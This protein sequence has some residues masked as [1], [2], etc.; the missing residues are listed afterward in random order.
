VAPWRE[1]IDGAAMRFGFQPK[2]SY[3]GL[4]APPTGT[5]VR[6]SVWE[7]ID[8]LIT[9]LQTSV[10]APADGAAAKKADPLGALS[11]RG[12]PA[13]GKAGQPSTNELLQ[14]YMQGAGSKGSIGFKPTGSQ[15]TYW[16][17]SRKVHL[18]VINSKLLV[19]V[20][21]GFSTIEDFVANN[22]PAEA[23]KMAE[24]LVEQG[25]AQKHDGYKTVSFQ[26]SI[27]HRAPQ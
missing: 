22:T 27:K 2:K 24:Q 6:K 4:E 12:R 18:V 19:R 14:Q 15:D 20:G 25:K 8:S 5:Q 23:K 1:H 21:G 26:T 13:S 11:P 17:G 3:S 16:F 7:R 9:D 10:P